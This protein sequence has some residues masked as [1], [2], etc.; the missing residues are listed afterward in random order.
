MPTY[1]QITVHG[2]L[3][4]RWAAWFDGLTIANGANGQAVLSGLMLDQAALQGVLTRLRDLGL[5]LIA[6]LPIG[7]TPVGSAPRVDS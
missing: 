6:V 3:D 7:G 5:P 1:Y 2:H 4:D